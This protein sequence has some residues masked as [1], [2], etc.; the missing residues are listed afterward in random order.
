[1]RRASSATTVAAARSPLRAAP[2]TVRASA[3]LPVTWDASTETCG[4]AGSSVSST[5]A[6]AKSISPAAPCRPRWS[7]PRRT[8]PAPM[9]VP[10][11][12]K[13]KSSTPRATPCHCSPRAA[14]LMSFSSVTGRPSALWSSLPNSRPSSPS[15]F[16]ARRRTPVS[17][18]TT[19]GTPTTT[20]STRSGIEDG[21]PE[22]GGLKPPD[23]LDR[24]G[25]RREGQL[26]VL[27]CA[28]R[29]GEVA[30][31]ASDEP[32]AE[33]E[34][35]HEGGVDNG[36]EVHGAVAGAVGAAG[37]F[38]D[39]AGVEQRLERRRDGRLRDPGAAGDLRP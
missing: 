1:M 17:C 14:R 5:P 7:S 15:T 26:D 8:T 33:I 9:P 38:A 28:D 19:P 32:R 31:G 23:R 39:Q 27:P 34:P 37:G 30:H 35:E 6:R 24:V 12:R 22:Q 21:R 29:P 36:L 2:K 25:H 18:S 4:A 10:I 13:T 3:G 11:E 16:S 20:L